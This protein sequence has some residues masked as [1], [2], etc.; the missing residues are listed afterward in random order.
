M[1][2]SAEELTVRGLAKSVRFDLL[3]GLINCLGV[4]LEGNPGIASF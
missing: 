3:E 2:N 4:L 1:G